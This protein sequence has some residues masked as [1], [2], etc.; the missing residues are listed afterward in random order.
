MNTGTYHKL[1][2]DLM[3]TTTGVQDKNYELHYYSTIHFRKSDLNRTKY[4]T[5]VEKVFL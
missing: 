1:L 4:K 3:E 5:F 2:G